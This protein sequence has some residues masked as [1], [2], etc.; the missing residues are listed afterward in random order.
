MVLI[1]LSAN[2]YDTHNLDHHVNFQSSTILS[3]FALFYAILNT[4]PKETWL[5][6]LPLFGPVPNG[7]KLYKVCE[8][9]RGALIRIMLK[10]GLVKLRKKWSPK[11][12]FDTN[13]MWIPRI[14]TFSNV[15]GH[16]SIKISGKCHFIDK[17]VN[18]QPNY[19]SKRETIITFIK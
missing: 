6:I 12:C 18:L 4:A 9:N 3:R 15:L 2:S 10:V 7:W 17:N 14:S 19:I 8:I 13:G 1:V 16:Q 11:G 5:V